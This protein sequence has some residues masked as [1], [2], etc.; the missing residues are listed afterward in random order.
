MSQRVATVS[1]LAGLAVTLAAGAASAHVTA[2]PSTAE[3]GSYSKV[4]FRVPNEEKSAD[5]TKLEVDLPADHPIASVSVRPVP[6][7]KIKVEKTKLATPLK[8]EG[9]E[10][11][12]AVS[13][14]TWSGGK[15][16]PGEF[17]EF[18]VSMGPLPTGVDRLMFKAAQTYSD[19]DVVNWN[20]DPGNGGQEPEHPAPTI[21]LVAAASGANAK[22]ASTRVTAADSPASPDDGTARLLGGLG[23]GFGVVGLAVGVYGLTR[24]R[25]S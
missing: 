16:T 18:D 20:Q 23:L 15:I 19:G 4:S 11:T 7:W 5:T 22:D 6:G 17:Q 24:R 21:H 13:K 25:A 12:E 10:L 2:N 9:G 1:A 14:I 8:V 3:P